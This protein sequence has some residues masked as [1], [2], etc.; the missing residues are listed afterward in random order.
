MEEA[1]KCVL[2]KKEKILFENRNFFMFLK[3]V[4]TE[5]RLSYYPQEYKQRGILNPFEHLRFFCRN[6]G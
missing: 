6:D 2:T 1:A 3:Y 4:Y 5:S